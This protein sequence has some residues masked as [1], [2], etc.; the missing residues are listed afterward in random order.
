MKSKLI[1]HAEKVMSIVVKNADEAL[2]S[3]ANTIRDD[4]KISM[5]EPKHG[6]LPRKKGFILFKTIGK[7][8]VQASAPYEPPAVQSG[9]LYGSFEITTPQPMVK[10]IRATAP[11]AHLLE[12]GSKRAAP[13]PFLRPS[14]VKNRIRLAEEMKRR[15]L[16]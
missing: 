5:R 6:K 8:K 7:Q 12:F 11:H 4:A 9:R 14:L 10:V 16:V 15:G 2:D 1:W 13:R 3:M